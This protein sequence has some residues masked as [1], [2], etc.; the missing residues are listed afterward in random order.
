[1]TKFVVHTQGLENYGAHCEDGQFSSG[2]AYWKFKGGSTYIVSDVDREQDAIAFV[3]AAFSENSIGW[4]EYPSAS[5]TVA[6]WLEGMSSDAEDYQDF[7]KEIVLNVSP[8]TGKTYTKG[9]A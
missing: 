4:K 5:Q 6:E 3:M 2:N 8:K 9:Y 1:M 7:Q